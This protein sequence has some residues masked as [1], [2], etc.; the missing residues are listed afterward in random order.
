MSPP[1]ISYTQTDRISDSVFPIIVVNQSADGSLTLTSVRGTGFFIGKDYA[2]TARHVVC[3]VVE[4]LGILINDS[5]QWL[6]FPAVAI[7]QHPSED[8]ALLKI[9]PPSRNRAWSSIFRP[10]G[11]WEGSAS[12]YRLFGYPEDAM[13]DIVEN[14]LVQPRPDLV[15]TQGYVKR[16]ITNV[17]LGNISGTGFY[18]LSDRAGSGYSGGPVL[19]REVAATWRVF[20]IYVGERV[21][22]GS[23][24]SVGYALRFDVLT[25]WES[26]LFGGKPIPA[27]RMQIGSVPL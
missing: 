1:E 14:G 24:F 7:D 10:S 12:R 26:S 5:G 3:P 4:G 25:S 2:L 13:Y 18:E 9:A 22:E 8:V 17:A 23:G 11:D 6:F 27:G 21:W 19:S 16:R 20:G 15:Y